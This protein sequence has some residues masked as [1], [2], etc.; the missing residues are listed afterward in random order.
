MRA[1]GSSSTTEEREAPVLIV[2]PPGTGKTHLIVSIVAALLNGEDF[3]GNPTQKRIICAT[4]EQ[5]CR[6]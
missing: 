4:P 1:R 2:G 3:D 5:Q 6:G